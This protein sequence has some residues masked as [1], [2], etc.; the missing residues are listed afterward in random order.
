MREIQRGVEDVRDILNRF[1]RGRGIWLVLAVILLSYV[2][3]GLYVV[4]PGEKGVVLLFGKVHAL[5]DP[6][7]RYRLPKPIMTHAIVDI[8]TVRRAEIGFRS[9]RNRTRSVPAESLMLTGDENIADVQLVVQYMVQ[10]P[11]KFLFGCDN[12]E[13]ALRVTA[14][15]ALRGVVGENEID[16]TMTSGRDEVQQKVAK[17]LQ[18]LLETYQ[19]GLLVTQ[20]RLLVVDPPAQVQEAFHDVVR[21]LEDRSRLIKEA[22]GYSEDVLPKARGQAQQEIRE[23]EAYKAQRVIRARGDSERFTSVLGEYAKSPRVTRERL[24]LESV[25]QFLPAPKKY[26]IESGSSGVLPLLPLVSPQESASPTRPKSPGQ[27]PGTE[28]KGN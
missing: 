2:A 12:P 10:D 7:L 14:E 17:A 16:H 24:Y 23:A 15:V 4:G 21:A 1:F 5:T 20:A 9:D 8:S 13:V 3:S 19:T 28:K 26:V 11:V 25:E 22:E 6:G 27:E 18:R